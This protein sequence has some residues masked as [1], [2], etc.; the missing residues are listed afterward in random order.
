M[1]CTL[2][3]G[4]GTGS[5]DLSGYPDRSRD[6]LYENGRL[7]GDDG[8]ANIDLRKVWRTVTP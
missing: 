1:G 4:C 2:L 3:F 8:Y 5:M 7:G 6:R